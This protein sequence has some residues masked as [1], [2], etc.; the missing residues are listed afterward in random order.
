M[1]LLLDNKDSFVWNLAQA[2][3][4]LGAETR[5][6]R[7]DAL[8]VTEVGKAAAVVISPG[9]GRPEDAGQS[10]AVV[11]QW[12]G[13]VPILGVCLGHQAIGA[14][15]GAAIRRGEPVHGRATVIRHDGDGLFAGLPNPLLACRYHSLYVDAGTLGPALRVTA[16]DEHGEVMAL[17]HV[18]HPT[19]GVQ[20]HP[21]SFRSPDG[22][23]LLRNFLA[24]IGAHAA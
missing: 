3:A 23:G 4:G 13:R 21:E 1:I 6:V 11:R 2:L 20:F 15:F 19:F 10:I 17:Q 7:S 14:A 5:V 8:E 24:G 9:P 18:Q 22:P 16:R 12:S